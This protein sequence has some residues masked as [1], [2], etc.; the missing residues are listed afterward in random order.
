MTN[1]ERLIFLIPDSII[2]FDINSNKNTYQPGDTVDLKVT[3][4]DNSSNPDEEYYASITV[5]DM[6]SFLE[7]QKH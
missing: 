4:P 1:L 5:T 7:V 2:N 3:I 6:S